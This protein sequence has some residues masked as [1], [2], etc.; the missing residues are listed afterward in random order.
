MRVTVPDDV[1]IRFNLQARPTGRSEWLALARDAEAA[2]FESLFVADHPGST[3]S[4]FVA[5]AAAA[6]VTD[7]IRLGSYVANAGVWDPMLLATELATLD[8]LSEGRAVFGVGAGHTPSEWTDRGLA[9]PDPRARVDTMVAVTD[10][11]IAW[12]DRLVAP[13]PVQRPIPLLVGGNGQRVL[14]YAAARADVVG[15]TGLGATLADGHSHSTRWSADSI[16]ADIGWLQAAPRVIE[17]DALV[18]FVVISHDRVATAEALGAE[19]ELRAQDILDC[20]Y[21]LVGTADQIASEL[22]AHRAR[23]AITRYTVRPDALDAVEAIRSALGRLADPSVG[24]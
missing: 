15:V 16:D 5:L 9:Y 21:A 17:L 3:A 4:P 18:Q 13:R 19:Y 22:L 24:S 1:P 23:W 11:T 10:A 8:E 2:R 14:R 20:P 6:A 7:R 12:L